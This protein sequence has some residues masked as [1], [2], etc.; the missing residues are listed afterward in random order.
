M[1]RA[2]IPLCLFVGLSL[3]A[4]EVGNAPSAGPDANQLDAEAQLVPSSDQTIIGEVD[5]EPDG[6][7]I[8]AVIEVESAPPG[9][10]AVHIHEFGNCGSDG[11]NAGGHWNP[12][13]LD[14]GMP[15]DE[16]S[17]LGDLG[18]IVVDA[19]GI[20]AMTF[21]NP[22]WTLEDGSPTD[23]IGHAV[24]VHALVDDFGQPTGNAGDRI[25]CGVINEDPD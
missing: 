1:T 9:Q 24:I 25:A 21:G 5:F 10:H 18:N 19:D 20:G 17:H 15:G 4:C 11:L 8:V 3:H 13:G 14:H 23:L 22:K 2:T 16:I 12:Q 7:V 6:D